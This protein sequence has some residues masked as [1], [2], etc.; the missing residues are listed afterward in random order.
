MLGLGACGNDEPGGQDATAAS[1]S[2]ASGGTT[3]PEVVEG[4]EQGSRT[5][6]TL[7]L[8]SGGE[9]SYTIV[10]PKD[11]ERG[12]PPPI[13]LALPPGGQGQREV[14]ALLDKWWADEGSRRGWIV[15]SPVAPDG[16][17]FYE[18][19]KEVLLQLLDTV[20]A[21]YRPEGG[22]V[23]LAGVSNGGLSAYRIALDAPERF[24]SMLV[25]PGAPPEGA[26]R[27]DLARLTQL[28]VASFVGENDG[29]WREESEAATERLTALGGRATLTI[30]PGEGHI[31]EKI[32]P[33][34]LF[35][36]LDAARVRR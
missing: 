5:R 28:P 18:Q 19:P 31:L 23:H 2:P 22:K 35:D 9:L 21:R 17:L 1:T 36:V 30:S 14:D 27:A 10:L 32:T 16:G 13:L 34:Q 12:A 11:L 15:V 6:E 33:A 3:G 7:K 4:P 8:G 26:A 20:T 24:A 29:G 25:A